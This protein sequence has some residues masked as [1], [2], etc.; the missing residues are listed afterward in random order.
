MASGF[1]IRDGSE[2]D[3]LNCI[4]LDHSYS[5]D[6]VWQMSVSD[7]AGEWQISFKPQRLPRTLETHFAPDEA[8]LRAALPSDQCFLVAVAKPEP[9]LLGYLTL[10]A[11]LPHQ[12]ALVQDIVISRPYRRAKIAT[13]LLSAA[14]QWANEHNLLTLCA[15]NQTKNYPATLFLQNAG[16]HFCGYNDHYFPNQEIAVFFSQSLR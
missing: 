14:R 7:T 2:H 8:R 10:R 6:F 11:N 12:I 4:E 5:T 13:R 9:I 16:F 1:L 3:I 15:E